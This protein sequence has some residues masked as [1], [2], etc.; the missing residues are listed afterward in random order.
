MIMRLAP[1]L[2]VLVSAPAMA[3]VCEQDRFGLPEP[4]ADAVRPYVVC[5]MFS[6]EAVS[7]KLIDVTPTAVAAPLGPG[8]CATI[9]EKAAVEAS[10]DLQATM[11]DRVAREEYVESVLQDADHFIAAAYAADTIGI[12]PAERLAACRT[13]LNRTSNAADQ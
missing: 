13:D 1:G 2:L 6:S 7:S 12:D 5:G 8:A 11:P 10:Q 4:I 3:K 9:R